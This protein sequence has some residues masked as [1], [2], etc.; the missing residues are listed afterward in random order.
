MKIRKY[1]FCWKFNW[2]HTVEFWWWWR[3]YCEIT[4]T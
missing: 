3:H 2:G 1:T 4:C